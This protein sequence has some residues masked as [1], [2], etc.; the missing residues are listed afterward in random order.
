M[1]SSASHLTK[2]RRASNAVDKEENGRSR[3]VTNINPNFKMTELT[4]VRLDSR[5]KPLKP[6]TVYSF[7]CGGDLAS[8]KHVEWNATF[9]KPLEQLIYPSLQRFD[10]KSYEEKKKNHYKMHGY[11][12]LE[13]GKAP[14]I[15]LDPV[16]VTKV[17]PL[18]DQKMFLHTPSWNVKITAAAPQFTTVVRTR[19]TTEDSTR[20]RGRTMT[21]DSIK[22]RTSSP[23]STTGGESTKIEEIVTTYASLAS[24]I[25]I[26]GEKYLR[27]KMKDKYLQSLRNEEMERELMAEVSTPTAGKANEERRRQRKRGTLIKPVDLENADV[28][29]SSCS[30]FCVVALLTSLCLDSSHQFP[31]ESLFN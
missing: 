12:S 1:K 13:A 24:E 28:L 18:D 22:A 23:A 17:D 20:T 11:D 6:Q 16:K 30:C 27:Q 26:E 25:E 2:S 19:S 3:R 31:R 14:N 15:L 21:E 10:M 7:H 5:H 29:V 9:D 4:E 8:G